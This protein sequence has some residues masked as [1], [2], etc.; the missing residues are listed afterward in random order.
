MAVMLFA[1]ALLPARLPHLIHGAQFLI[2]VVNPPS[3]PCVSIIANCS[4]GLLGVALYAAFRLL[5]WFR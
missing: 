5:C 4:S 3:I 1:A 2:R